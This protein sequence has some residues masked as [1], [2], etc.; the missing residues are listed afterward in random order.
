M[1]LMPFMPFKQFGESPFSEAG[2]DMKH[3]TFLLLMQPSSI[4]W[5]LLAEFA[6]AVSAPLPNPYTAEIGQL[7]ISDSGNNVSI[8]GGNLVIA[9]AAALNNPVIASRTL[10][11][12]TPGL[13]LITEFTPAS[14]TERWTLGWSPA[15]NTGLQ[16][17]LYFR[18]GNLL[19]LLDNGAS[20]VNALDVFVTGTSYALG[21]VQKAIGIDIYIRGGVF[22]STTLLFS[23]TA[24][25]ASVYA[26][27]GPLTNTVAVG[28]MARFNI[29]QLSDAFA[30]S[31]GP[32]SV[33]VSTPATG[34]VYTATADAV[35]R[36]AFTS[37]GSPS[38]G[39]KT[40]FEFRRTDS[41]NKWILRKVRNAGNTAW[42]LQLRTV[43]AGVEATPAGWADV[44]NV[45]A[46]DTFEVIASGDTISIFT[47]ITTAWTKQSTIT[48]SYL[49]TSTDI[50]VVYVVGSVASMRSTPRTS[51]VF[52]Q[53]GL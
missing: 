37:P 15:Q 34:T 38:A 51:G 49:A 47:K 31:N 44:T 30:Q 43:T 7:D 1:P 9:A 22:T 21:F 23:E 5:L 6:A 8:S 28:T 35:H 36:L 29:R 33:D 27:A 53:L 52:D 18:P 14:A 42:D 24:G 19:D 32:T 40:E 16:S 17:G 12:R 11:P 41:N 26:V 2:G 39:D 50:V 4:A 3:S 48:N 46:V 10:F 45:G 13:A 25:N 20:M